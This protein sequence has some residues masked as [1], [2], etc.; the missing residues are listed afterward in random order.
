[1]NSPASEAAASFGAFLTEAAMHAGFDVRPRAGGRK[2][3]AEVTGI[4]RSA[5]SRTLEGKTLPLPSQ[6]QALAKAVGVDLRTMLEKGNVISGESWTEPPERHVASAS[7]TPEDAADA[8]GIT[9]VLVRKMLLGQIEQAIRLQ[10]ES[11]T[12]GVDA[13]SRG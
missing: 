2:E 4:S 7:L 3:L 1:M 10:Q 6:M 9:N 13:A 12:E 8:W 11:E 5:I